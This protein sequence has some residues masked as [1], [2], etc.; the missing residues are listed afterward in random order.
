[1]GDALLFQNDRRHVKLII[2]GVDDVFSRL[3]QKVIIVKFIEARATFGGL[4]AK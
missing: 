3:D 1:V 4:I 2:N